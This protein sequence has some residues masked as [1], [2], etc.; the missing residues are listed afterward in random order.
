MAKR[1]KPQE[2]VLEELDRTV[3]QNFTAAAN[4]ISQL[5]TSAEVQR[6]I[7]FHAGE[8]HGLE[9]LRDWILAKQ[10]EGS[11]VTEAEIVSYLQ[12]ELGYAAGDAHMP[13]TSD[14]DQT[15]SPNVQMLTA[16]PSVQNLQILHGARQ[17]NTFGFPGA[18]A[19]PAGESTSLHMVHG[20]PWSDDGL[21]VSQVSQIGSSQVLTG[22]FLPHA[23][24]QLDHVNQ[25][26]ELCDSH[27][28]A[29]DMH[30]EGHPNQ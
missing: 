9:K 19:T 14:S 26:V 15:S 25:E 28:S 10:Q 7:T 6:R 11:R 17:A 18:P 24:A 20:G 21:Q 5:Y 22:N 2:S 1:K 29:M 23:F 4:S 30:I 16:A 8:Q 13:P 27:D 12:H 3:F